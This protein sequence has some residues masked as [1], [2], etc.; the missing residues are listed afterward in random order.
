MD[1]SSSSSSSS[2]PQPG[3]VHQ[4]QGRRLLG[5][6]TPTGRS[7][8]QADA[9]NMGGPGDKQGPA[10][11]PAPSP[12]L[13]PHQTAGRGAQ[14]SWSEGPHPE[15]RP[16]LWLQKS[17]LRGDLHTASLECSS[18]GRPGQGTASHSPQEVP[19]HGRVGGELPWYRASEAQRAMAWCMRYCTV[20][21]RTAP[22]PCRSARA[23]HPGWPT[24][25]PAALPGRAARAESRCSLNLGLGRK[26][27][28]KG[29]ESRVQPEPGAGGRQPS[30]PQPFPPEL[31][32]TAP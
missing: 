7:C 18:R 28:S 27:P 2:S 26:Q 23:L 4:Q 11:L 22:A 1:C 12:A 32:G 5:G 19:S 16:V 25:P 29:P 15:A 9:L 20:S 31:K 24:A 10:A 6:A 14:S 13:T 17:S 3:R 8:T 21:I 30:K